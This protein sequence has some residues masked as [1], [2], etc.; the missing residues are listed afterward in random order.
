V[1]YLKIFFIIAAAIVLDSLIPTFWPPFR[2]VDLPL[3]VT[4]Y[5]GLMRDPV[6]GMVSGYIAGFGGD[7]APGAGPV[8]GVGGFS[9]TIIGFLV[10]SVAFR[11]SLEGPLIR[12]A[13]IAISSLVN[14]ALYIGLHNLMQQSV[15]EE[16][17]A[18]ALG[19]KVLFEA[20]ANV[21]TGVVLFFALDKLFP[22]QAKRGQ[23]RVQRRFYD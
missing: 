6:T 22:E 2:Y 14:S 3:L 10:A 19:I 7:V 18:G 11:F 15:T 1:F 17:S 23:M 5:C 13:V 20:A 8:I 12:V 9:K 16:S 4:I 21:V